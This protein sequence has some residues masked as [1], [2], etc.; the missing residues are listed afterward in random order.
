MPI[1][2]KHLEKGKKQI[3]QGKKMTQKYFRF[4]RFFKCS[5]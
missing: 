1:E 4:K 5:S 3:V 2:R